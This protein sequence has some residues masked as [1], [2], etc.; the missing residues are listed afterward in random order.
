MERWRGR[1]ALVTGASSG[2]G[3][4]AAEALAKRGVNV[5]GC[6]RNLEKIEALKT[7]MASCDKA[8]T[9]TAMRCDVTKEEDILRMFADIAKSH[10]KVDILINNAGMAR[11][12]TLTGGESAGWR[13]MIDINVLGLSLCSREA[14]KQ[15]TSGEVEF[16]HIININSMAGHAVPGFDAT[17]FYSGT[18]HMVK[19]LTEALFRE[20]K[21]K[22]ANKI[23]VTSLSPGAVA[24]DFGARW[25][26]NG[27]KEQLSQNIFMKTPFKYLEAEDIADGIIYA[28]SAPQ[29]VCVKEL[30][31]APTEQPS[32]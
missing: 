11:T 22:A 12:D 3:L 31:L 23:R 30:I 15:M 2:I 26:A 25:L 6:A 32:F 18:K 19:A 10:K 29:H 16:G 28:L 24:T 21:A 5:I 17:H 8:G 20:V 7:K 4:A 9:V 27:D 1:T 13:E 14:F